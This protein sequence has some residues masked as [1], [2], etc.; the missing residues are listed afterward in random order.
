VVLADDLCV[1]DRDPC[2]RQMAQIYRKYRCSV[3]AIEQVPHEEVDKYGIIAG[4]PLEEGSSCVRHGREAEPD[5]APSNLAIIGRYILTPDIFEILRR[6]PPGK[7]G[8]LQITD[9]L[10][11]QA[12]EGMVLAY[13]FKGRRFDCAASTASSRRR[14]TSTS[15]TRQPAHE[16]A[17][18]S[19]PGC[20]RLGA[21][22][23]A[24]LA[25]C[26]TPGGTTTGADTARDLGPISQL[27]P[28][29]IG[30]QM[31]ELDRGRVRLA[32]ESN[33]NNQR[34]RGR[35]RRAAR[36]TRSRPS[37]P[38]TSPLAPGVATST[39]RRR[40]TAGTRRSAARPAARA[41]APGAR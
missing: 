11:T 15:A 40:S 30:Q 4:A 3:V 27:V 18:H 25:G 8:E 1:G 9:A 19:R 16:A 26:A 2:S 24:A 17:L 12:A 10:K 33:G 22:L 34:A 7:N 13:R 5:E 6:T 32:L 39:P 14:I 37:A 21:L 23:V 41:T 36:P 28:G 20:R 29:L 38:S 31:S 35:V